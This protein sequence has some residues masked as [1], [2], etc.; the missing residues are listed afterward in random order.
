MSKVVTIRV[1]D[2]MFNRLPKASLEGFRTA[3]ILDALRTR[4]IADGKLPKS[5]ISPVRPK[6]QPR[7]KMTAA[8]AELLA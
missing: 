5:R 8:D 7:P 1:P 3:Y 4:M 6:A 2:D